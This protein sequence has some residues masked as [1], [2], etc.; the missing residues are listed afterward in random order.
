ME[1][2]GDNSLPEATKESTGLTA[3]EM[4]GSEQYESS[5]MTL[6]EPRNVPDKTND[7]INLTKELPD[8][9]TPGEDVLPDETANKSVLSDKTDRIKTTS[10]V[11]PND[12]VSESK[13]LSDKTDNNESVNT[14]EQQLSVLNT[15]STDV[16]P[17][18]TANASTL[19]EATDTTNK[20]LSTEMPSSEDVG[21][22]K[23][24]NI[25][26]STTNENNDEV[27]LDATTEL[28]PDKT[29]RPSNPLPDATIQNNL[30]TLENINSTTHKSKET[31]QLD[32]DSQEPAKPLDI[33]RQEEITTDLKENTEIDKT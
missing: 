12:T 3:S 11:L 27:S 30:Q 8:D 20:D 21:T 5:K 17:D 18:A 25:T 1:Y 7:V 24:N 15:T 10:D 14:G 32:L 6:S 16:Y 9:T 19:H 22:K 31:E 13:V 2:Q 26:T 4:T 29:T 28:L 23:G 33:E